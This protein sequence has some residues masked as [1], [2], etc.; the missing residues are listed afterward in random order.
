[1]Q[2]HRYIAAAPERR[3]SETWDTIAELIATTLAR[4]GD[5]SA[6]DV[7]AALEVV[8]PIGTMLIAGGHVEK[9]PIIV[10]AGTLHLSI[11]T[12]SGDA[13][14]T[15]EENLAP[16]PGATS[17]TAWTIY[18]P[19]PEP[20]ADTVHTAFAGTA[21]VSTNTPPEDADAVATTRT[22]DSVL[23]KEALARRLG[24]SP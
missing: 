15:L 5:I 7:A 12:V 18:I 13:A 19:I 17:A 24:G 4:S 1:M 14:S 21:H 6:E 3:S 22:A 23:N 11:F 8:G 9:E 20:L 16:V 10:V 2:R